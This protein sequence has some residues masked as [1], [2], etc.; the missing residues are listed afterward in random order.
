MISRIRIERLIAICL[1]FVLSGCSRNPN[2]P[3]KVSGKVTH[4]GNKVT[5]G[6]V[7][8]SS[9]DRGSYTAVIKSDG[10]YETADLPLGDY[11]V[12]IETESANPDLKQK[13]YKGGGPDATGGKYGKFGGGGMKQKERDTAAGSSPRPD[14]AP[15]TQGSYTK[16]PAKYNDPAQSGLTISLSKGSNKKDFALTD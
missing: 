13:E 12:S 14:D 4:N 3:A 9:N 6:T 5:A 8:F 11:M 15:A 7:T 1:V 16:I 10:T 2:A